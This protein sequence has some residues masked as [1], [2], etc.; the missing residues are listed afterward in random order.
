MFPCYPLGQRIG[1]NADLRRTRLIRGLTQEETWSEGRGWLQEGASRA[2]WNLFRIGRNWLEKTVR[3]GLSLESGGERLV[4]KAKTP[5]ESGSG[6]WLYLGE[7]HCSSRMRASCGP[8]ADLGVR[9]IRA[10]S[11]GAHLGQ[12]GLK[13]GNFL[14]RWKLSGGRGT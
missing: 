7:A 2:A 6:W 13:G 5:C 14:G 11:T 8:K 4:L 10:G 1:M 9:L 12:C 3:G